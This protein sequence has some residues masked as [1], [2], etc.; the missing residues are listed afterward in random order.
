MNDIKIEYIILN[1]LL[2]NSEYCKHVLPYLKKEYFENKAEQCVYTY[3]FDYIT[4]YNNL[5]NKNVL[6]LEVND[7]ILA[8]NLY[9]DIVTVINNIC[10]IKIPNDL[11]YLID[12]T[13]E[14]CKDKALYLALL[15][16]IKIADNK[17]NKISRGNIPELLQNALATSFNN[18]VGMDFISD[19]E[20]RFDYYHKKEDK[21]EFDITLLNKITNNGITPKTLNVISAGTGVGKSLCLAHFAAKYY[22]QGKNVLYITLEMAEEQ[23]LSRIDAN[24]LNIQINTLNSIPK[25]LYIKSINRIKSK[26]TGKLIVKEFPTG[27]ATV[28]HIKALLND[29]KL[30]QNFIPDVI[31]VDYLN[32]MAS[33]RLQASAANNTYVYVKAIAEELRGLAVEYNLIIWSATQLNRQGNVSS[34]VNI[35]NIS[36]SFGLPATVDFLLSLV[37]TDE[38]AQANQILCIQ[39]KNRYND[40]NYY[41]KFLIGIDR[42]KMR[43]YN[44]ENDAQ[45]ALSKT[46]LDN[47][48]EEEKDDIPVFDVATNNRFAPPVKNNNFDDWNF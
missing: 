34:D 42:S 19:A 38:L 13:E 24:L 41:K 35:S 3:I 2:T 8:S 23:I 6:L 29:L 30:K 39:L 18:S 12:I 15:S 9:N 37:S 11:N 26:T 47:K 4:K 45:I 31:L 32:I 43:L 46:T 22:E 5:P 20:K 21:L 16:S 28:N 36:E 10:D 7:S 1:G 40:I 27:C 17:S 25:D 14:F 33:S 48:E 44:L